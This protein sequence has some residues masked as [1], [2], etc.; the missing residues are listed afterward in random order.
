MSSKKYLVLTIIEHKLLEKRL[1]VILHSMKILVV[2]EESTESVD[3]LIINFINENY[4]T[5]GLDADRVENIFAFRKWCVRRGVREVD[6]RT[7]SFVRTYSQGSNYEADDPRCHEP[8]GL[9]DRCG[10]HT[11]NRAS[12]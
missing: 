8:C 11:Y 3:F 4:D 5:T 10:L 6:T 7:R 1:G 9:Q 12:I 2:A